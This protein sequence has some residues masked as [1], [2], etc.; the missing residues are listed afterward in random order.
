MNLADMVLSYRELKS[1]PRA[2]T[3]SIKNINTWLCNNNFPIEEKEV[4]FLKAEDLI[5][6]APSRKSFLRKVF[7]RCIFIPTKGLFG[8]LGSRD[9]PDETNVYGRDEPVD[10]MAA[11]TIF[12]VGIILLIAPLWILANTH[13]MNTRLGIITAF[14]AVLLGVLTSGTLAKPFEILAATAG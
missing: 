7:E 6:V 1:V 2:P 5:T 13:D 11:V 14:I 12:A 3:E 8:L 4:E 10:A 9:G